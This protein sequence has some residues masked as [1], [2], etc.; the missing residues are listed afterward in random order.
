MFPYRAFEAD[1]CR[2]R[3]RA[4]V[5]VRGG[6]GGRWPDEPAGSEE[7]MIVCGGGGWVGRSVETHGRGAARTSGRLHRKPVGG[8]VHMPE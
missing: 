8:R 2:E 7:A 3:I 1:S 4:A 6:R 5:D